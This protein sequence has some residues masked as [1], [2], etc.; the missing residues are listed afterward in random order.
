[1]YSIIVTLVIAALL[2][3][4]ALLIVRFSWKRRH[5]IRCARAATEE[6]LETIYSLL[7]CVGPESAP[8]AVLAR[9]NR[10]ACD[11]KWLIPVPQVLKPW[12]G[13]VVSADTVPDL[14]FTVVESAV[15]EPRL[16]GK[17]YRMV[18][19]PPITEED[20]Q[21]VSTIL[22][23][24]VREH[25]QLKSM[26]DGVCTRYPGELLQYLLCTGAETFELDPMDLVQLGGS[27]SWVQDEEFPFCE[28]CQKQMSL[29]LQVPGTLLPG[30]AIPRGTFFFFG[31]A[32][33]PEQT[34][35]VGQFT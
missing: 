32:A 15:S 28:Q 12:G 29:I 31:C 21:N 10:N 33:H 22:F 30:R 4:L 6:Q 16:R 13:R 9:T 26:L 17:V 23:R 34:K 5:I 19:M 2:S 11:N 20:G 24:F 18:P 8:S 1:M 35:T 3:P 7:D 14:S 27:P 25:P